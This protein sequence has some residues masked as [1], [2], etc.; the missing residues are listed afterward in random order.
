MTRVG[1]LDC[2]MGASGDMLLGALVGAGVG[3]EVMAKPIEALGLGLSLTARPVT[4]AGLAATKVDVVGADQAHHPTRSLADVCSLLALL[5]PAV[6]RRA[7]WVFGSLAQAEAKAH[8]VSVDDVHFHEVGALDSIADIVGVS[9]GFAHLGLDELHASAPSLGGGTA[10]TS[11][12]EIPVPGPAVVELLRMAQVPS[13]GGPIDVE[14]MTP[15]GAALLA[16]F[17]RTWGPQPTMVIESVGVGAGTRDLEP[18]ANVVRLFIGEMSRRSSTG[19]LDRIMLEATIDDLEPRLWPHVISRLLAIGVDDAWVTPSVGKKDRP[20]ITLTA[21]C[22]RAVADDAAEVFFTETTTLGLRRI[23][24]EQRD[25]LERDSVTVD[26]GGQRIRVKRG[27]LHGQVVTVQ[28]E[29]DDIAEAAE[30]L[31]A[32]AKDLIERAKRLAFG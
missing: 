6:R 29:W 11:H 3:I 25:V 24:V 32:P 10:R 2:S 17:V 9:A 22:A 20:G 1:W 18:R 23:A 4:K 27:W 31:Q 15:T 8:G 7:E 19:Q 28:P 16:T 26:V 13:T 14:L 5:D 30:A 21:L 12:G